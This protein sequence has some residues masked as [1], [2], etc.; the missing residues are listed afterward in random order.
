MKTLNFQIKNLLLLIKIIKN[1]R[2]K[3]LVDSGFKFSRI[4]L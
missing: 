1:E 3:D 2:E 4:S